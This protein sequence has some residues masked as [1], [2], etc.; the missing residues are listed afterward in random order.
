MAIER[1]GAS[2][3]GHCIGDC[4]DDGRVTITEIVVGV[5]IALGD[6]PPSV[7]RVGGLGFGINGLVTSVLN[8][9][10]GC[11]TVQDQSDFEQFAYALTPAFGFCPPIGAVYDAVIDRRGDTYV[12]KRSI[13]D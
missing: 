5:N 4:N 1:P 8:A 9:L 7:C 10:A 12:L 11:T 3:F 2:V 13:I 6:T